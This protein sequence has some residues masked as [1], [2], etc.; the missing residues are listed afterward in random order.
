MRPDQQHGDEGEEHEGVLKLGTDKATHETLQ[1]TK[2]EPTDHGAADVAD[3]ADDRGREGLDPQ[4]VAHEEVD[5][6]V[7]QP[8]EHATHAGEGGGHEEGDQDHPIDVDAHEGRRLAVL[9]G[10]AHGAPESGAEDEGVEGYHQRDGGDEQREP[11]QR[12]DDAGHAQNGLRNQSVAWNQH[13]G[14]A[15]PHLDGA[16]EKERDAD[17]GDEGRQAVGVPQRPVGDPLDADAEQPGAADGH[18]HH[19]GHRQARRDDGDLVVH[20]QPGDAGGQEG[21]HHVDVAVSEIQHLED[22]VD[23]RIAKRDQRIEASQLEAIDQL[24]WEVLQ[25]IVHGNQKGD[26]MG[27]SPSFLLL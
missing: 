10:G 27:P 5:T 20:Q 23:Q 4:Q 14:G 2:Q 16:L 11:R 22:A 12:R 25:E 3:A 1:H 19:Q 24:L 15:D 13:R 9:G 18:Q 17:R 8:E 6:R 21:A 26:G 7:A